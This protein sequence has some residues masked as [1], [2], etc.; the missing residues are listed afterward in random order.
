M[1][2]RYSKHPEIGRHTCRYN[3]TALAEVD[4]HDDSAFISELDAWIEA[5]GQWKPMSAALRD[6][7]IISDNLNEYFH[8]PW[9]EEERARGYSL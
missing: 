6:R 1:L 4:M 3:M 8:E 5:L 2:L 7:D 9:N